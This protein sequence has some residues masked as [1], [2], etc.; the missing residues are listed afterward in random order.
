MLSLLKKEYETISNKVRFILGVINEEIKV[1]RVKKRALIAQLKSLKFATHSELNEI[2]PERKRPSVQALQ[3]TSEEP[4]EGA[5]V[6]EP[7]EQ[8]R[9]GEVPA[10]EYDYLLTM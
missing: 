5:P 2:L 8:L 3:N 7:E 10:K 4:V 1:S 6:E 9:E